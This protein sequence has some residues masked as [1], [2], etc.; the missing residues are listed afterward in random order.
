M[1]ATASAIGIIAL[2]VYELPPVID[3]AIA[4]AVVALMIAQM[5]IDIRVLGLIFGERKDKE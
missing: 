2:C 4:F 3:W 1:I 5:Y